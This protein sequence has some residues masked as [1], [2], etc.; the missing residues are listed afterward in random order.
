MRAMRQNVLAGLLATTAL[1]VGNVVRADVIPVFNA[2]TEI[3]EGCQFSYNV[4]IPSGSKV[5]TGDYFTIYDFHGYI[6]GSAFAPVDW[7]ISEQMT[8]IT[9]GGVDPGAFSGD[10]PTVINLTFEYTGAPELIG[11]VNPV[12]GVGAFGADSVFCNVTGLGTYSSESHKHNPGKPDD[13]TIQKNAGFVVTPNAVPEA[14]TLMI[15]L[16]GLVPLGYAIKKRAS[17]SQA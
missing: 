9:P 10:D 8:G 12:G 7:S 16:P 13:D 3:S 14:S 1:F 2:T 5:K 6:A 17:K 15:L 11:E 4:I